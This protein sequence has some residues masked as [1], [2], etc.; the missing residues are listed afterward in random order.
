MITSQSDQVSLVV[1]KLLQGRY[2]KGYQVSLRPI[3]LRIKIEVL[4][5]F[6][7]SKILLAC[8][9]SELMLDIQPSLLFPLLL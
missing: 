6:H 1:G 7:K 8:T 3:S 5:T 2:Y 9:S 4:V